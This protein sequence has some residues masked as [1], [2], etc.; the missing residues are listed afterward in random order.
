MSNASPACK[1]SNTHRNSNSHTESEC[2]VLEEFSVL[3]E[4]NRV[5]QLVF[6]AF[7]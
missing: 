2:V 1:K 5:V 4:E 6:E 3:Q 7:V